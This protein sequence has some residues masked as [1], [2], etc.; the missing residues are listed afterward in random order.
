MSLS[1][2]FA[3]VRPLFGGELSQP[4]V[5]GINTIL[6]AWEK[7]GD[8][9]PRKLAYILATAKH[10]T[11]NTMQPVRETLAK[12]DAKAKEIL[13]KAWK[14]GKLP[15]VKKDYWSSGFFGRGFVQ[16]THAAN[17][18]KAGKALGIDLVANP[19]RAMDPTIS[20]AILVRGMMEG[21]FT[22]KKLA[23]YPHDFIE[24]RRIVN[25]TDK[26]QLIAGYAYRFLDAIEK[27]ADA[28]IPIPPK[29]TPKPEPQKPD[30]AKP[31]L[32]GLIAAA[33]VIAISS[34]AAASWDFIVF[35][36]KS[37]VGLFT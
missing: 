21:W 6:E 32:I 11:A 37:I 34:V 31:T 19:S 29:P 16:L 14:A 9:D 33:V 4:Q 35:L 8:D 20:A 27:S 30:N 2:F 26:A 1:A 36:W 15:W 22:G 13:T 7:Y 18:E 24:S 25:G 17:Y 23:D 28:P 12:T 3:G 10:E 5:D